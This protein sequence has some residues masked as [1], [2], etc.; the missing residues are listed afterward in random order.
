MPRQLSPLTAMTSLAIE[1]HGF[2]TPADND[3]TFHP[4]ADTHTHK[5]KGVYPFKKLSGVHVSGKETLASFFI[6]GQNSITSFH[7]KFAFSS[8]L[9]PQA[10][11]LR[12]VMDQ[13]QSILLKRCRSN[14]SD[15][16][17]VTG[18]AL[19]GISKKA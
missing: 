4:H 13:S 2:D 14:P 12:K 9:S 11:S 6:N 7:V 19:V 10:L 1:R 16:A 3:N 17:D 15:T 18:Q 8:F 5:H